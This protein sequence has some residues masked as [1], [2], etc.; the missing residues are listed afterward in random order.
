MSSGSISVKNTYGENFSGPG[1]LEK[2]DVEYNGF[3]NRSILRK[4]RNREI[5]QID[6][7]IYNER[8]DEQYKTYR[9]WKDMLRKMIAEIKTLGRRKLNNLAQT[10]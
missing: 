4:L 2:M 6:E 5:P 3:K 9:V 1:K 8:D 7:T 10:D